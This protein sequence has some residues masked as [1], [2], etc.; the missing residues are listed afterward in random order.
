VTDPD[1]DPVTIK[2]THIKQDEPVNTVG[3]GNTSCDA[4]TAPLQVRAERSG[5]PQ[6]P[7]DGR[8]YHIFFTATDPGGAMCEG[9]VTVVVPHDQGANHTPVDQGPLYDSCPQ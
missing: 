5:S 3:D 8:F 1:N 2:V 6:V 9:S 4:T 7:G